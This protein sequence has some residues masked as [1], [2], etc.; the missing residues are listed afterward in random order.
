MKQTH[1]IARSA[2]I[3][4]VITITL[5]VSCVAQDAGTN[6][7]RPHFSGQAPGEAQ[8]ILRQL[9]GSVSA[10]D[11]KGMTLTINLAEGDRVVKVTAKTKLSCGGKT[12]LL[13]DVGV[14]QTVEAVIQ[15]IYGHVD[16]AVSVNIL[17]D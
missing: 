16:E 7:Y 6:R 9:K 12:A 2:L 13:Q 15:M 17:A 14:G 11:S 8:A 3:A 5:S 1:K 4:G 10:V